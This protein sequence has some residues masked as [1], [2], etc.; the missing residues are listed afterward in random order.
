[1]YARLK[2]LDLYGWIYAAVERFFGLNKA[3]SVTGQCLYRARPFLMLLILAFALGWY[4]PEHAYYGKMMIFDHGDIVPSFVYLFFVMLVPLS[5]LHRTDFMPNFLPSLH[6]ILGHMLLGLISAIFAIT[7]YISLKVIIEDFGVPFLGYNSVVWLCYGIFLIRFGAHFLFGKIYLA[8]HP[9]RGMGG[10]FFLCG[11]LSLL[12]AWGL[13][14]M[15]HVIENYSEDE[16]FVIS[17]EPLFASGLLACLVC[18]GAMFIYKRQEQTQPRQLPW[19]YELALGGFFILLAGGLLALHRHKLHAH[20]LHAVVAKDNL[21][22]AEAIIKKYPTLVNYPRPD[23][24]AYPLHLARSVAMTRLLLDNDA[25]LSVW[26]LAGDTPLHIAI[27]EN[28]LEVAEAILKAAPFPLVYNVD[29][30]RTPFDELSSKEARRLLIKYGAAY[31]LAETDGNLS[32][33]NSPS[34]PAN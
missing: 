11:L 20:D 19:K 4:L 7:G 16:Y 2:Y 34:P 9:D 26:D 15:M 31:Q 10:L 6:R 8:R 29:T 27:R 28:R 13:L 23:D 17:N 1:M 25:V 12:H 24:G 33:S 32:Q 22:H 5:W 14:C 18:F 21:R 30:H 3:L